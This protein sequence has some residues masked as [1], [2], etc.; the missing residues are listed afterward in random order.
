MYLF[1]VVVEIDVIS[2]LHFCC[3]WQEYKRNVYYFVCSPISESGL[4]IYNNMFPN[5]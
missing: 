5:L 4:V 2:Y 1:C 3:S